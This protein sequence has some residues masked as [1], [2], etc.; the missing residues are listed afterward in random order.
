MSKH[1]R[2]QSSLLKRL[3]SLIPKAFLL[4]SARDTNIDVLTFTLFISENEVMYTPT[5]TSKGNITSDFF[6]PIF[7]HLT[8]RCVRNEEINSKGIRRRFIFN[9][10]KF[11]TLNVEY[12][13]R[14]RLQ[15][16]NV[17][18]SHTISS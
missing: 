14:Q 10:K 11:A 8:S 7:S 2:N 3:T 18:A 9:Y 5:L 15:V 12:I 17:N 1:Q 13:K 4:D 16:K 6:N